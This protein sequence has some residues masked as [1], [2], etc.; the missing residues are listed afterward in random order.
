MEI[1]KQNRISLGNLHVL[2]NWYRVFIICWGGRSEINYLLNYGNGS[3][4]EQV[5]SYQYYWEAL[6]LRLYV[7][8]KEMALPSTLRSCDADAGR[9][10]KCELMTN[11]CFSS[12]FAFLA[13]A[14]LMIS[15]GYHV[16]LR[17]WSN[18]LHVLYYWAVRHVTWRLLRP[19]PTLLWPGATWGVC[20]TVREKFG[21]PSITLRRWDKIVCVCFFDKYFF[22]IG[23]FKSVLD[24][25]N[26]KYNSVLVTWDVHCFSFSIR[27]NERLDS[28]ILN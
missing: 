12:F 2:I 16:S 14:W 26:Q 23:V 20:S 27:V 19:V 17:T 22:L 8:E 13:V 3:N 15:C 5:S 11:V 9:P 1:V 10:I 24:S 28:F 18:K 21:W 7:I 25:E 4:F 6:V